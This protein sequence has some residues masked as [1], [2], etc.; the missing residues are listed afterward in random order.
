M[1]N[2][3]QTIKVLFEKINPEEIIQKYLGLK[4]ESIS[5]LPPKDWFINFY[6]TLKDKHNKDE[7]EAIYKILDGRWTFYID[8]YPI[9]VKSRKSVFYTLLVFT[10][11]MLYEEKQMPVCEFAELLRWNELT[12]LLGEDLFTTSFFAFKDLIS[13]RSRHYFSWPSAISCNNR[14]LREVL[15]RGIAELHFHLRGSAPIFDIS[16]LS[17]MNHIKNRKKDF[18][19]IV[20]SKM[21][22][23]NP[24]FGQKQSSLYALCIKAFAIRQLIFKIFLIKYEGGIEQNKYSQI[25]AEEDEK[26]L[27]NHICWLQREA[28]RLRF[29]YGRKYGDD[30]V[31]YAIPSNLS[32]PNLKET[33]FSNTIF[34]GERWLMYKMFRLIYEEDKQRKWLA[35]LFYAY[36]IIKQRVRR[37]LIHINDY[38]GFHNFADYQKRKEIF[39][40]E[41][42]I[43]ECLLVNQAVNGTMSNRNIQYLEAR[44][45]PKDTVKHLF[46]SITY[47]D[48][49][50][51]DKRFNLH[52]KN[53]PACCR[54]CPENNSRSLHKCNKKEC[55]EKNILYHYILHF[56]K[57]KE[58]TEKNQY[59]GY[60]NPR[61]SSLR[62]QIKEQA[63]AINIVRRSLSDIKDR[64]IG[65]DAANTEIGCRP[66]VFA[67]A[68]RYLKF[69]SWEMEETYV[70]NRPFVELGNTFHVGEDFLD[71]A[72]GLRAID[73]AILFLGLQRGD[74]LGHG[75]AL[76]IDPE[77]YYE[78]RKW[79]IVMPKQDFLDNVVWIMAKIKQ[80][81][82][83]VS[84]SL[85]QELNSY[86]VQ[87]LHEIYVNQIKKGIIFSD[88]YYQAWMLRG[89][90]PLLYLNDDMLLQEN[91][92]NPITFWDRCGLN[93]TNK[94]FRAARSCL[95]SRELYRAYHFDT[96]VKKR[97]QENEIFKVKHEYA[98]LIYNIQ[99]AM[100]FDI[101]KKHISLE[102]NPTSNKHIG[103]YDK[104]IALP[105]VK[106]FFN[107]GLVTEMKDIQNCPQLSVSLNTDDQG[108]FAT[109]LENEYALLAIALEKERDKQGTPL[110]NSRMIYDWLERI[111]MM[112]FEQRFK[113]DK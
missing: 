67:Q 69:Y 91:F 77:E 40:P 48:D 95:T 57:L 9:E 55:L 104:Y 41:S 27:V 24:W 53:F 86:Y 18:N 34:Y 35:D 54:L 39:I 12:R 49:F 80:Y 6:E 2:L 8:K 16:W 47:Y 52:C 75:L 106:R 93:N 10:E 85:V 113:R 60:V 112:G 107:L 101:A 17:I 58:E 61:N 84:Q 88:V 76:G 73:E 89:D 97:G 110:Y 56:I 83:I 96:E 79:Q 102:A 20:N 98:L 14:Q 4:G 42:S 22:D 38:P 50:I 65:I 64:I 111:R 68:Y 81:N 36:L 43:Y 108:V 5:I 3:R 82:I 63:M 74:R 15:E 32:E 71:I 70:V 87:L 26:I 19:Q 21:P 29:L 94:E 66:E 90:E 78:R 13:K 23:A 103:A 51:E 72:D 99:K 25:L 92:F 45:T 46:D 44:I 1:D 100:G 33:C 109:N 7:I 28:D 62:K 11:N 31:D 59:G 105:I 37:E 30:Y